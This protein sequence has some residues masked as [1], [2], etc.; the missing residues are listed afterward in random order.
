M[1]ALQAGFN[2]SNICCRGETAKQM[3]LHYHKGLVR[4][5]VWRVKGQ[6]SDFAFQELT[7]VGEAALLKAAVGYDTKQNLG[8]KFST[9]AYTIINRSA[10]TL[11]NQGAAFRTPINFYCLK[12]PTGGCP[13]NV[14]RAIL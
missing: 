4:S 10:D 7:G 12:D 5:F 6:G 1:F 3:L 8:A 14:K 11:Q 13:D 2:Q 9:Y